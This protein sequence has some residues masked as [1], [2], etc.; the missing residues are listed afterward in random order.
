MVDADLSAG[1]CT[2]SPHASRQCGQI[3]GGRLDAA[4]RLGLLADAQRVQAAKALILL[5][6][7]AAP[8]PLAYWIGSRFTATLSAWGAIVVGLALAFAFGAW[9]YWDAFLGPSSRTESLSGLVVL[10]DPLYQSVILT[11]A[12]LAASLLSRRSG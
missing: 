8:L 2:W 6:W 4:Q 1:Q 5:L 12:L 7:V 11:M 3:V 10:H 9:L